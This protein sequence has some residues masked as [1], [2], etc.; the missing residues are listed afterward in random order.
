M[1]AVKLGARCPIPLRDPLP[2]RVEDV[3]RR[4]S[5]HYSPHSLIQRVVNVTRR[6]ATI[7]RRDVSVGIA[8]VVVQAVV[9]HV[10]RR[11]VL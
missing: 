7:H 9:G 2:R 10:A 6:R 3:L 1:L 11:A 8:G 5:A 4:C